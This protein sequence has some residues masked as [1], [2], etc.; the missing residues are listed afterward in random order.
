MHGKLLGILRRPI[1]G[2][3]ITSICVVSVASDI[4][5]YKGSTHRLEMDAHLPKKKTP[6]D[7]DVVDHCL[8]VGCFVVAQCHWDFGS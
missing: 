1:L 5:D 4:K 8:A 3:H 7:D 2:G 6:L